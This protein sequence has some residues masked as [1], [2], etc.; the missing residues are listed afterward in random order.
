[1]MANYPGR[2]LGIDYGAK[3]VGV[4][5]SDP[6]RLIAQGVAT[7]END[8]RLFERLADVVKTQEVTLIV[9]GMP[10]A[11]DGGKSAKAIEVEQFIERLGK[12][13]TIDITTWD[14][15]YSS[16]NAQRA[17][18]DT[19]MKKKKRQQKARVDEM[20]ARLMLQEFLDHN[21]RPERSQGH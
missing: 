9:V 17:F 15:S 19:G 10:Y 12:H 8:G 1:M 18:I 14:E 3:R 13:A 7:F 11:A 4:A 21:H 6:T 2:V 20:A 16:V 5:A